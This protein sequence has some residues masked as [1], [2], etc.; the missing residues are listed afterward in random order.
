MYKALIHKTYICDYYLF[1]FDVP[2][3]NDLLFLLQTI[4]QQPLVFIFHVG[5][6]S[7]WTVV[8]KYVILRWRINIL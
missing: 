8:T 1:L 4:S 3:I 7:K 5:N 6:G 2:N